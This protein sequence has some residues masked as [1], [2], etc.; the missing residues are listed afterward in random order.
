MHDPHPAESPEH[1]V[2]QIAVFLWRLSD[3]GSQIDGMGFAGHFPNMKDGERSGR[4]I[5]AEMVSERPFEDA[6]VGRDFAFQHKLGLGT[7]PGQIPD[8]PF[9]LK[10]IFTP[11]STGKININ[12]ADANVLQMIPYVDNIIA[13]NI[14]KL[15]AG[16]DGVDGTEDD[17]PSS[18]PHMTLNNAGLAD[19]LAAQSA[20]YC[21]ISSSTYEVHVTAQFGDYK[22]ECVAILARTSGTDT[23]VLSF[24]WK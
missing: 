23:Q 6:F 24:Y 4:R 13:D 21:T 8:Y 1:G 10:D 15:R 17:T 3:H 2:P 22:R 14:I 18:D 11:F 12:T 16:P 5:M 7:A 9:G 19:P 20:N